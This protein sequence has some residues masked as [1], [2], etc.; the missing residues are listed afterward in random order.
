MEPVIKKFPE[1]I[2][3][4]QTDWYSNCSHLDKKIEFNHG[5]EMISGIFKGLGENGSAILKVDQSE[6]EFH[7][8][9]IL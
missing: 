2:N 8:G 9:E 3:S 4:I 7:S 1:N 5:S 6:L